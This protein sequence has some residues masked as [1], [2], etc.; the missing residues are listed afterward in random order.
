MTPVMGAEEGLH[1]SYP[2]IMT[3]DTRDFSYETV[4]L[5]LEILD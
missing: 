4:D 1:T 3:G 5:T 2:Q